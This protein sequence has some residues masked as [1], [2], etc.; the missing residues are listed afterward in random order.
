ML[1]NKAQFERNSDAIWDNRK[2]LRLGGK[3]L[4]PGVRRLIKETKEK[5]LRLAIA[6]TTTPA[7]VTALLSNAMA[8]NAQEWFDVIAAGDTVPAKKPAPD[9]YVWA[10]EQMNL[11]PE[12]CVALEDSDNG[13]KSVMDA[14]IRS[15]VVT[16]SGYTGNQ[17]FTGAPLVLD[18]MGEPN[19]PCKALHGDQPANGMLDVAT[20]EAL[21]TKI[22]G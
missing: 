4:R 15:V 8:P 18:Q 5:G 13:L 9:I 19:S 16:V 10:M 1:L 17:D 20:L 11:K 22:H 6:T 21:H 14:G 3:H 2:S 7:N 12:Q